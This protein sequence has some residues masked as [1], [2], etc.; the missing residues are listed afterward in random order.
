MILYPAPAHIRATHPNAPILR[1]HDG[2]WLALTTAQ[3]IGHP[4]GRPVA[5][6][7]L[8]ADG[9]HFPGARS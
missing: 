7:V 8:T 2:A 6:G 3:A 9:Q 1:L 4:S 5:S